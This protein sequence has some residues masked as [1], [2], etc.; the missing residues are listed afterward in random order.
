MRK[1]NIYNLLLLVSI[2]VVL[3]SCFSTKNYQRAEDEL[4]NKNAFKKDS[5]A[6]D[7]VSMALISWRELFTDPILQSYI[8]EGLTN[9]IDIKIALQ[10]IIAAEAYLKQGKAAYFPTLTGN[11]QYTHQENSENSQFGSSFPSLDSYE[12][13]GTLSWEADIWGKIRSNKRAYHASYLQTVA[14]HTAVK[15]ELIAQ[16]ADIYYQLIS[17]DEQIKIT[18]ETIKNRA[19]SVETTNA[20]KEAGSVTEVG[21]KQTEAQLYTAQALLIDLKNQS[22][23]LENT[24]SVLLGKT[25]ESIT[26]GSLENQH[27]PNSLATGVP[28]QLLSNRPDL[29][30]AE[31]DL[32]QAF[33]LSNVARSNFYPSLTLTASGGLQSL[34]FDNFF[35]ANS[36]FATIVGG[37]T[38]PVFNSRKIRSQ[39]EASLAQQEQA[40]LRFKQTFLTANK[41]VSDALYSYKAA[42][43]KIEINQK[44]YKAYSLASEYSNE[45]LNNGLANYLE[46][47]RAQEYALNS[48]LG[49]VTSKYDQLKSII[50]LYKALGGGWK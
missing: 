43:D 33:E 21:V 1:Q 48:Q 9:N 23:L 6:H 13:S 39:Y 24:L 16:I 17:V 22:W 42:T 27:I 19:Q 30:A 26:R 49:L 35:N 50:N 25:P 10:Q 32:I 14:A 20:L 11:A 47:L 18:E 12:L 28:S 44:E 31:Y 2:S 38:Q 40:R 45:L 3:T 41:E 15:S 8:E 4:M 7:T 29:I 37:I 36:L 46:V 5:V 34:E